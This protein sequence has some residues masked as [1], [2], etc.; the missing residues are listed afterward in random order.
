[1]S[2]SY[3]FMNSPI[4]VLKLVASE[5]GLVAVL[6]E[7]D[8]PRRVRLGMMTEEPLH[9]LLTRIENELNEYFAGKR[10]AFSI[11]LDVRGTD[12][13]KQLWE[14]LLGIPFGETRTYG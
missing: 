5:K 4:G 1:M 3:K 13:Q 7:N 9:P 11:P 10:N 14:A 2:M 12:F 6:W 8:N